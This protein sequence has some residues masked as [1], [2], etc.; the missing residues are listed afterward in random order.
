LEP[1]ERIESS[2]RHDSTLLPMAAVCPTN[3]TRAA[4]RQ[5]SPPGRH[6]YRRASVVASAAVVSR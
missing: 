5:P 6:T 4:R 1:I 2:E 3:G